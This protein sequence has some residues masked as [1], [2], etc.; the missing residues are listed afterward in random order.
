MS[1]STQSCHHAQTFRH[2]IKTASTSPAPMQPVQFPAGL[3]QHVAVD[4]V[5]S[6]EHEAY[7]CRF[8]ITLID[9]FSKWP[10]V[11]FTNTATT[12]TV[13]SF[14]TSVF[15]HEGNP[16]IITTDNGPQFT[17]SAFERS[18]A[19]F[20]RERGIKHI[21][22][23]VYHLQANGCV[24]HFNRELKDSLQA[25]QVTQQPWKPVVTNM[26]HS[27]RA[28]AHATTGESPFQLL[29]GRPMRTKLNILPPQ[30]E[31]V[32]YEHVR[33][34]V[35]LQQAKSKWYT[36]AKRGAKTPKV[37]LGAAVRVRKPFHVGKGETKYSN[38]LSVQQQ[39]CM[40][41]FTL[42]D[43]RR[44]NAARLSLCLQRSNNA[45]QAHTVKEN[46]SLIQTSTKTVPQRE[47][48]P[49]AWTI[50]REVK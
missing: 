13:T 26:L 47:R 10:E 43:G 2:V 8:A 29:R 1:S 30:E 25:A 32:Q 5:G 49:P 17:S 35:G 14:L 7:D 20:L 15:A 48:Q 34:R 31:N 21:R 18:S 9:Y 11:A 22:T 42:S 44:W 24:E 19:D 16:C 37:T 40:S 6:F 45:P 23:S 33:A 27:Y 36:D 38:P 4:I 12:T 39:T 28:T 3:F 50:S 46:S 41:S